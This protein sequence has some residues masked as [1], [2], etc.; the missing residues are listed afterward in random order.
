MEVNMENNRLIEL[1]E[2]T[3][4]RQEK[5]IIRLE[6]ENALLKASSKPSPVVTY[7]HTG[8]TKTLCDCLD[9]RDMTYSPFCPKCHG[10][11]SY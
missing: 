6:Q 1:L 3:I 10:T 8:S 7:V 5:E 11:G 4:L 2:K 9:W